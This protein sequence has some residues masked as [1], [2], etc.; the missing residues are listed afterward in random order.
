M[1]GYGVSKVIGD[2]PFSFFLQHGHK[3]SK[4]LAILFTSQPLYEILRPT[5]Q[6]KVPK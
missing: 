1:R 6:Y 4:E 5:E 3:C 2:K